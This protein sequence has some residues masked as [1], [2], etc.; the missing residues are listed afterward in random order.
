M[1]D[2]ANV[3]RRLGGRRPTGR[4]TARG[5]AKG[6]LA[7]RVIA[8]IVATTVAATVGVALAE[9]CADHADLAAVTRARALVAAAGPIVWPGWHE[10]PPVL[11]RSGSGDC[12]VAHPD[13]PEGFVSAGPG[14]HRREGH[15]LPVPAATAWSVN[16]RWS[17]AIPARDEL[18]AFL[19]E[20]LGAGLI[21]LDAR[22]YVRTIVH[23][24]F[25][26]FQMTVLGGPEAIPSMG[27]E[28]PG[29]TLRAL[30]GDAAADA[31]H[32][33]MGEALSAA[34]SADARA[35]ALAAL[36]KF[37]DRRD[38]WWAEAPAGVPGLERHLEWLEGTARYA[39][40]LIGVGAGSAASDVFA[41]ALR[42]L[43]DQV[44]QPT[45][46]R[47]G[48][49]DR[50]AAFGAAQAFVLDRWQPGWKA[51]ALPGGAS[52]DAL[53]RSLATDGARLDPAVPNAP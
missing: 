6:R 18:Q 29:E 49:R 14:T 24:A 48:L 13:P 37:V 20:H 39:D 26:A 34:L 1:I 36:T 33:A 43:H 2:R 31:A 47:S 9:P 7:R 25:H 16:D 4:P 19:D 3:V 50:Y 15:L 27:A 38:A 28:R 44:A 42:D 46:I 22:L 52:L 30:E 23:E 35:E 10:P 41:T 12:L 53:I 8:G 5:I 17:V 11:I 40:V 32:R 51:R 21:E 45:E